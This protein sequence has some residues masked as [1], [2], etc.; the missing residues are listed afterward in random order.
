MSDPIFS[1]MSVQACM[2]R[3]DQQ[4]EKL[5]A[6]I[7]EGR[8]SA[9]MSGIEYY[10]C[11]ARDLASANDWYVVEVSL[12]WNGQAHISRPNWRDEYLTWLNAKETP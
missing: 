4:R 8:V 2:D 1:D 7:R 5:L 11:P 3:Y 12:T 10:P 6:L 9:A